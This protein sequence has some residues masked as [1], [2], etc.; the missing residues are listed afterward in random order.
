[1]GV[2]TPLPDDRF[3]FFG[4]TASFHLDYSDGGILNYVGGASDQGLF[5]TVNY[6][7]RGII[8]PNDSSKITWKIDSS[9]HISKRVYRGLAIEGLY[10]GG[11]DTS[12]NYNGKAYGSG[13]VL[14]PETRVLVY[15]KIGQWIEC[16]SGNID[17]CLE[18]SE[19]VYHMIHLSQVKWPMDIRDFAFSRDIS[20]YIG[21]NSGNYYVAGG[22]LDSQKVSKRLIKITSH[23]FASLNEV[24]LNSSIKIYPNPVKEILTVDFD[25]TE[26]KTLL[27]FNNQ[28]SLIGKLSVKHGENRIDVSQLPNGLYFLVSENG[29]EKSRFIKQ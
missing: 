2:G 27:I 26:I 17:S 29:L 11:S 22:I 13:K 16:D 19:T 1:W 25:N 10:F 3:E 6:S 15:N 5:S 20:W 9:Q 23:F 28:G 7:R 14:S 4:A 18:S 12:Y 8:N 21:N 24:E